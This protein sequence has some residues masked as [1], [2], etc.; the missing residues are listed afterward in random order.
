MASPAIQGRLRSSLLRSPS[1]CRAAL[2]QSRPFSSTPSRKLS[3]I[4][5]AVAGPNAVLSGIHSLGVPWWAA[6]PLSAVFARG[7]LGYYVGSKPDRKV[8]MTR[9]YLSPLINAKADLI[10]NTT[11][12]DELRAAQE[13]RAG[14]LGKSL[15]A[16]IVEFK[17]S[18]LAVDQIAKPYG[19][20]N[21]TG[22][23]LFNFVILIAFSETIR[24]KSGC[25]EGLLSLVLR[26]FEWVGG[27]FSPESFPKPAESAAKD[28]AEIL[29][30][31]LAAQ[32]QAAE[33]QQSAQGVTSRASEILSGQDVSGITQTS[34]AQI[35]SLSNGAGPYFDPSMLTE[36]MAW[37]QNLGLPDSTGALPSLL[38]LT[39]LSAAILRPSTAHAASAKKATKDEDVSADPD[40]D[41]NATSH[42]QFH[43]NETRISRFEKAFKM[44]FRKRFGVWISLLF[45]FAAMNMP[46]AILLYFIPSAAIGWLQNR[47]LDI[48]YPL[49]QPIQKC[50]R[51]MR[52]KSQRDWY[53]R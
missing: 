23:R 40:T 29:A 30:E 1:F 21:I 2:L 15:Q 49:P 8:T 20:P 50:K 36:G 24:M 14:R 11:Y 26:P 16:M 44:D 41:E 37:F 51:P 7:V 28:P 32:Q 6:I 42:A 18:R 35:E 27:F 9:T 33:A 4:D 17:V 10:R 19:A 25:R 31:K 34:A 38:G 22:R 43:K 5:V 48:K 3:F 52:L 47:W 45:A 46:A 39:M 13:S 53:T 12:I